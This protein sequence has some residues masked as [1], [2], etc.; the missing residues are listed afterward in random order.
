[1]TFPTDRA[2]DLAVLR[3]VKDGSYTLGAL[4]RAFRERERELD[5]VHILA[6]LGRLVE[7][8]DLIQT[9]GRG[10]K[11]R[12]LPST[13]RYGVLGRY[14]VHS[15]RFTS[16]V[17]WD[18]AEVELHTYVFLEPDDEVRRELVKLGVLE[19]DVPA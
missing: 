6:A 19:A 4:R 13:E 14:T 8:G 16:T 1:M 17:S 11:A 7:R 3:E 10:R 9:T 5:P 18:D 2:L 15:D 12:Y